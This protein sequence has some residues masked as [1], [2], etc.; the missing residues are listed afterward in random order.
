MY[1][2][3]SGTMDV[4]DPISNEGS[5]QK[6]AN[7]VLI[8]QLKTGDVLGEM[9]IFPFRATFGNGYFHNSG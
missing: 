2:I 9:G 7:R 4:F 8:N 1:T 5:D 6:P 3:I